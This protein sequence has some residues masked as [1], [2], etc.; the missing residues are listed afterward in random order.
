MKLELLQGTYHDGA[1]TKIIDEDSTDFAMV[2][3]ESKS[4]DLATL[5]VAAPALLKALKALLEHSCEVNTAFYGKGTSKALRAAMEGQ[6]ELLQ[7][8]RAAISETIA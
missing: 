1:C 6:R 4:R 5:L 7:Q 8:A 3:A 2:H